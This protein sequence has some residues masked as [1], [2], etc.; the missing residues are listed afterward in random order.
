MVSKQGLRVQQKGLGGTS[1]PLKCT[2]I[3]DGT[4][5]VRLGGTNQG[6]AMHVCVGR[7]IVVVALNKSDHWTKHTSPAGLLP[8]R[9]H[10]LCR[11]EPSCCSMVC[12]L[13]MCTVEH[14]GFINIFRVPTC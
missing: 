2:Y 12:T 7:Q 10:M 13:N 5:E 3:G 11:E 14:V 4:T 6:L 9:L 1:V 8:V